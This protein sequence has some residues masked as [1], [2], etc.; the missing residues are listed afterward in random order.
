MTLRRKQQLWYLLVDI[1]SS[2]LVWLCFLAFR[3]MAYEGRVGVLD[4]VLV[5]AFSFWLPLLVYPFICLLIYYLSG[6]YLRPF[7]KPLWRELMRT[8]VSAIIIFRRVFQH[9]LCGRSPPRNAPAF[10]ACC[11]AE[12]GQH[13]HSLPKKC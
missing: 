3:W 1:V 6:Y 8:F 13:Q 5:P 9:P 4:N 12:E 10:S 11:H 2:E 7:Q